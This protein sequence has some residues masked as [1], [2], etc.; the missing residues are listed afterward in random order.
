MLISRQERARICSDSELGAGNV[1]HRIKAYDRPLD[2]PVLRT[3]GKWRAPDGS[4][5][6]VLTLGQL[7]EV[8]EAYAGW[9]AARGVRP[10]D[11]VAIHSYSAGEFAVNFLALTA[12]GAIPSF[13][14]GNLS[15]EIAREYIRRQGAVGAFTDEEHREVLADSG[16]GFCVTAAEI[17]PE[18]RASLPASYPYRH[19]PTDP[20]LISHSSGTTGLPKG[21]PHTHRTL[22]YAQ[23]HRL[24]YSTGTDMERTLVGLPGAHNAMVAT[25]LYCLLLRADIKL[26]SSQRGTDVLD[27]I[28]EFRPTT[29]LAFAGT[30]GEMAAE[31]LTA[32]D[33]S[34]VQ[35]WFNTGDAA[36]EAHIRALVQH[37]GHIE[38]GRDLK[39][40]RVD[41][42]VFVDGLGSS[43]AGYSVFH[44]RHTKDTSAYSR[45]VGKPISFA[46]A[47]VLAEDGTPLP[48]GQIG[49]LGLKSPTLTPGYWNDS[50]TWNRMRLGGYWL[51]GDLAHQDEEGNFY[52]LDRAPDA[53][54]T[55]AGIVFSTRTE[56]LLLAELP[57]LADC[58][59]VGVAPDGVRADWDGDGE[60]EAYALLQLADADGDAGAEVAEDDA[61]DA[62]AEGGEGDAV[63]TERVNT[64]LTNAGFPP[65]SRALR[66]KPDDVAKGATGKVL[67]RVMRDRFAADSA[68]AVAAK[69]QHA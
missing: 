20:V 32:R 61:G 21:V 45:R 18:H 50:V 39:R 49:R 12:L 37:G 19:D 66:M 13:V 68:D 1:L 67:K 8:V 30:F 31:D 63:W 43:E 47:A 7:N 40:V 56:E 15:P 35:V 55:R 22:M 4:R 11:P 33:L 64:V 46:E 58:T 53:I 51:T 9:Y 6:E 54:R 36:H 27:A 65:L 28:E 23:L 52:H 29:V 10:R 42:S 26:L 48:P 25:L 2:E 17:R 57:G 41:G 16:L 38:V 24:R 44:N 60:A 5:P 3:D 34:S 14:N 62:G 59:V 69:E